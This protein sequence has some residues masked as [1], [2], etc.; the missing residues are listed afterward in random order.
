MQRGR[1]GRLRLH[2]DAAADAAAWWDHEPDKRLGRLPGR[3]PRTGVIQPAARERSDCCRSEAARLIR[4]LRLGLNTVWEP[5][6]TS[7]TAGHFGR[8]ARER[9]YCAHFELCRF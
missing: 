8:Y 5:A 6:S 1:P 9:T 3:G 7:S 4:A 2:A